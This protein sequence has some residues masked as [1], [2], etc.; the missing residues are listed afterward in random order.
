MST[1]PRPQ[2]T[3]EHLSQDPLVVDLAEARALDVA[4][5]GAKAA[6]LARL[7]AASFPVPPGLVVTPDAEMRWEEALPRLL[8]AAGGSGAGRFAVRS[9]GTAED[10]EDASFAGQYE[11]ILGVTL[12]DLP[13]AVSKVFGSADA[14]RVSAYRD[15]R[16]KASSGNTRPRMAVLVQAMVEADAAGVAFTANP[17]T[18]KRN[19]VVITAVRELGERLVSGAAVGDEW[20]CATEKR[21]VGEPTREPS[22]PVRPLTSLPWRAE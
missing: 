16:G 15:A 18:G 9:S 13:E 2:H 6:S 22:P 7:A 19:E 21:S 8:E 3:G 20:W 1:D 5:I 4:A 10:L 12:D 17:L 11:T 14:S